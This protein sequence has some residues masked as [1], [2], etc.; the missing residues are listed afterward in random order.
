[1][2]TAEGCAG[3]RARLWA[4][5]PADRDALVL[6]DPASL[7]YFANFAPSPFTFRSVD[8]SAVLVLGRDR[9]TLVADA[10][11]KP[12]LDRAH[13]DEVVAPVWYDGSQPAPGRRGQLARVAAGVVART[14]ARA[15][16]VEWSSVPAAVSAGLPPDSVDLEP[17][18]RRL[19]RAK[20]PDEVALIRRSVRAGE[21]G[22]AAALAELRPGL[23]ELDAFAI[24]QRAAVLDAGEPVL[25]YGD[26]VSGPRCWTDRGGPPTGRVI[27]PGDLFLLDFSVVV[28]GYRA[29]FTNTFAVGRAPTGWQAKLFELCAGALAEGEAALGPG[30][31]ARSVDAAVR[32][33][34]AGAGL[35]AFFP[36]HTGHGLGLSH[37][38]PPFL[39]PDGDETV[40]AGDVVAV[41]PGLYVPGVGGMR[42]ERNYLVT[43][44]GFETLTRHRIGA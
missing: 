12:D 19:R 41:E 38:E 10:M 22:H 8:A 44:D 43:A 4:S 11:A 29:D 1:M 26:F 32:G 24:V 37:P 25:V 2:L 15:W 36:S 18:V 42:F 33:H 20:D 5:L 9:A 13:V 27:E 7:V 6:A 17:I 16:G 28:H 40:E 3:R 30:V 35:G 31:P 21:A 23:T 14:K 39:V 34:F